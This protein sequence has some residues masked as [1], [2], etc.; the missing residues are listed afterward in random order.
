MDYAAR[1]V[2]GRISGGGRPPL[3][4]PHPH[5]ADARTPAGGG[6]MSCPSPRSRP[7]PRPHRPCRT[8][9]G[10]HICAPYEGGIAAR[11]RRRNA[12]D[13]RRCR[14]CG[15]VGEARERFH[16]CVPFSGGDA[17]PVREPPYGAVAISRR[18]SGEGRNPGACDRSPSS[19]K[20]NHRGLS[21]RN[22]ETRA[23]Y[24]TVAVPWAGGSRTAPTEPSP[25]PVVIP[26]KAGI[27]RL[28]IVP[29]RQ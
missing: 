2:K 20:D 7:E 27:Q 29:R 18:H 25:S 8:T 22:D 13:P 24:E 15:F 10:A 3:C 28:V 19:M 16:S 4:A 11:P 12:R 9:G 26:A 21:L 5:S 6:R 1:N 14:G 23:P 17:R